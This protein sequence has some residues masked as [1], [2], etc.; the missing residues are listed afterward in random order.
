LEFGFAILFIA[1]NDR[2]QALTVVDPFDLVDPYV[3]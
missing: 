3:R 2:Y 1:A